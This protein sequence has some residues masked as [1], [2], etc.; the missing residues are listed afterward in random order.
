MKTNKKSW[1]PVWEKIFSSQSW[2]KY[3]P[4]ELV[5][6]ISRHYG[7]ELNKKEIKILDLGCGTGAATWFIAREGYDAYGVDASETGIKIAK[8]RLKSENLNATFTVQDFIDLD[9]PDNY[10]DCVVDVMA[11]L[12]NNLDNL[13]IIMKEINRVIKSD[14]RMFSMLFSDKCSFFES[15]REIKNRGFMHFFKKDELIKLFSNFKTINIE[16]TDRTNKGNLRAYFI[17]D[18]QK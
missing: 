3:P 18:A 4:E 14:G 7:K 6:F 10:F 2:G 8:E 15:A 17:V 9:Y 5:I 11:L 12:A 16:T 1:D 13:Q